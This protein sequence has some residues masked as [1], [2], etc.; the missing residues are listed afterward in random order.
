MH[1]L[2]LNWYYNFKHDIL[3][4]K[5]LTDHYS[6]L[7]EVSCLNLL[8]STVANINT[9]YDMKVWEMF[10]NCGNRSKHN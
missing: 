6:K 3:P 9:T 10:V 4:L 5:V 7:F 8:Y 2:D 1:D